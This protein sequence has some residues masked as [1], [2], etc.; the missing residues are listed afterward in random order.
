MSATLLSVAH[1]EKDLQKRLGVSLRGRRTHLGLTQEDVAELLGIAT[2]HYQK[3]EAGEINVTLRTI[4][5]LCV[6]LK[7]NARDLL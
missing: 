5:R 2:R 4:S 1:R 3:I 7:V 6:A